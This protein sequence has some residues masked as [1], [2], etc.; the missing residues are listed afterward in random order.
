[1]RPQPNPYRTYLISRLCYILRCMKGGSRPQGYTIVEVMIFLAVTGGLFVA[2][3]ATFS[4]QQGKAQFVQAARDM[5]SKMQDI[6]NDV[7]TGYYNANPA[8]NFRCREVAGLPQV[9]AS[10]SDTQGTND[11]CIFIGRV[12]HF[13]VSGSGGTNYNVYNVVGLRQ[14]PG[15]NPRREAGGFSD[16]HPTAIMGGSLDNI[17]EEEQIPAGL[18][19]ASMT[20]STGGAPTPIAAIG[21]FSTFGSY[22]SGGLQSNSLGVNVVPLAA[23]GADSTP[24]QVQTAIQGLNNTS[25]QN[26]RG[27][28][29]ICMN[30]VTSRQHAVLTIGG[31]DRQLTTDLAIRNNSCP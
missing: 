26:P 12:A 9:T 28:V 7:S 1:M 29:A 25:A 18:S 31:N 8:N 6:I 16:A 30:S 5:E 13:A 11:E 24:V 23:G 4:G 19:V 15:S 21:F 14:A 10:A 22:Q 27:G 2:I 20:Y 3:V 17:V